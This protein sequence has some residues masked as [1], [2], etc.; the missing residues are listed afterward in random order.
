[1][2][3]EIAIISVGILVATSEIFVPG[4]VVIWIGIGFILSGVI[5]LALPMDVWAMIALGSI[6]GILLMFL[7]REKLL[8]QIQN[9]NEVPDNMIMH[10]GEGIIHGEHIIFSGTE[11]RFEPVTSGE[12]FQEGE[13]AIVQRIEKNVAYVSKI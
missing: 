5:A 4:M 13:K 2:S 12:T 6:I 7:F 9:K 10:S 3:E 11:F 8:I 1:M